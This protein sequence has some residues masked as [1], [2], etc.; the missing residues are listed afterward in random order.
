MGLAIMSSD[1]SYTPETTT[2]PNPNKHRFEVTYTSYHGHMAVLFVHY[3]DCTTFGGNKVMI[4]E[5]SQ[6]EVEKMVTLDPHFLGEK[7]SPIARFSGDPAGFAQAVAYAKY[8]LDN[9]LMWYVVSPVENRT[10]GPFRTRY[11]ASLTASERPGAYLKLDQADPRST[12]ID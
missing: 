12:V 7:F 2:S 4:L 5:A 3:P 10:S 1:S 6:D 8:H 11:R 9:N